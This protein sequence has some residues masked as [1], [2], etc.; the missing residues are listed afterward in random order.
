LRLGVK[1]VYTKVIVTLVGILIAATVFTYIGLWLISDDNLDFYR[2]DKES[3]KLAVIYYMGQTG[4]ANPPTTGETVTIDEGT[5]NVL[6]LCQLIDTGPFSP[7]VL[8]ENL[9]SCADTAHDNCELGPCGC[10]AD[11]HYIWLVGKELDFYSTCVGTDCAANYEDGYQ[12]VY[13]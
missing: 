11:A 8:E 12:G 6:D 13:P 7:G 4:T 10:H 3:L 2:G 5:F 9:R 1:A